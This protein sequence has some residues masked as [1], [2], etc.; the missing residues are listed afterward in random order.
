MLSW[1][2]PRLVLQSGHRDPL[3]LFDCHPPCLVQLSQ[4]EIYQTMK[5]ISNIIPFLCFLCFNTCSISCL[6]R[7]LL[8]EERIAQ[9]VEV[10]LR[11]CQAGISEQNWVKAMSQLCVSVCVCWTC[12]KKLSHASRHMELVKFVISTVTCSD[13]QPHN[14]WLIFI[15]IVFYNQ[16]FVGRNV[17]YGNTHSPTVRADL[18]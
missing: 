14:P 3:D 17:H 10:T 18:N 8:P 7:R 12:W 15:N 5:F 6:Q 1:A 11:I 9:P 2:V 4:L 16:W 13:Q